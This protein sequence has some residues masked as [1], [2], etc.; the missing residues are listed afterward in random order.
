MKRFES[1]SSLRERGGGAFDHL[2]APTERF[3]RQ[4]RQCSF[5][6]LHVCIHMPHAVSVPPHRARTG[7]GLVR[8]VFLRPIVVASYLD[9]AVLMGDLELVR[10]L[11]ALGAAVNAQRIKPDGGGD[12]T[13]PLF[14]VCWGIKPEFHATI[15]ALLLRAGAEATARNAYADTPLHWAAE[16]A[17]EPVCRALIESGADADAKSNLMSWRETPL[18]RFLEKADGANGTLP[19]SG[20]GG[21]E[22]G[23]SRTGNGGAEETGTEKRS[24][25][26]GFLGGMVRLARGGPVVDPALSRNDDE[27]AQLF[28]LLVKAR[29]TRYNC[30]HHAY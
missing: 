2:I 5:A 9:R 6:F 25:G 29:R 24:D 8:G 10:A 30:T 17:S 15:G 26:G 23:N 14:W 13:T 7:L 28:Q 19:L 1:L 12:R 21:G 22:N 27:L 3:L 20:G 18:Y 11:I 16:R 4:A